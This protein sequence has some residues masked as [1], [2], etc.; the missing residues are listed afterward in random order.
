MLFMVIFT[1]TN[2]IKQ[3][4]YQDRHCI[5]RAYIGYVTCPAYN[6]SFLLQSIYR[7]LTVVHPNRPF[8]QS[9]K[10]QILLLMS[11]WIFCFIYPFVFLFKNEIIYIVDNQICQIPLQGS[12]YML[13]LTSNAYLIP[14]SLVIFTYIKLI[15]YV[16]QMSKRVVSANT[17]SRARKELQMVRR[18]VILVMILVFV[19]LPYEI[20]T[21]MS[22]FTNAPKYDFRIAYLFVD[23]SYALVMICLFQ[24]TGPVKTY[25]M[26]KLKRPTDII[27][28]A[29]IG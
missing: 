12:F 18:I 9:I 20:F 29:R 23:L 26:K 17:L 13:Y 15:R 10:F 19:C 1:L 5:L 24:F 22:L 2:D 25:I 28:V 27:D 3:I 8:W 21:I 4:E 6:Y 14:I 11:T 16:R 7:Y